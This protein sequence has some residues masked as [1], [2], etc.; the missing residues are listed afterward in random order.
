MLPERTEPAVNKRLSVLKILNK[1]REWTEEDDRI[2]EILV[3]WKCTHQQI[4]DYLERSVTAVQH[5]VTK[6][7]CLNLLEPIIFY[8]IVGWKH[9][10][11]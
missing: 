8:N 10:V 5:R 2:L 3:R 4:A 11:A 9:E 7:V 1:K 6:K